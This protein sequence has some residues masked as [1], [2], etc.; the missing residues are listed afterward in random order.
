MQGCEVVE[1]TQLSL[2]AE[3]IVQAMHDHSLVYYILMS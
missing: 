1:L 2:T 3:S